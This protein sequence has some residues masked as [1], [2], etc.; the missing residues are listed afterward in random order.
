MSFVNQ[1]DNYA[2]TGDGI[3]DIHWF[4]TEESISV[5]GFLDTLNHFEEKAK[6]VKNIYAAHLPNAFSLEL[7]HDLQIATKSIIDGS[8]DNIENADYQFLVH[9]D[10]YTHRHGNATIYYNKENIYHEYSIT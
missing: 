6:D 5:E 7:I 3:A 8:V 9:G 1:K 4:D 10:L 2:F